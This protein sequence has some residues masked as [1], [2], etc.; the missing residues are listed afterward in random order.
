MLKNFQKKKV[1]FC[2]TYIV[3]HIISIKTPDI[4]VIAFWTILHNHYSYHVVHLLQGHGRVLFSKFEA[5]TKK[6]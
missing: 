3:F 5:P 6:K 1:F 2:F 4:L